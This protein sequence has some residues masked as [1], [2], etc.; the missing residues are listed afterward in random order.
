MEY[1]LEQMTKN[2]CIPVIDIFNFYVENSFAAFPENK[3]PYEFF[4]M[5]LE[6]TN[7]LPAVVAKTMGGE[8][9]GF[10]LLRPVNPIPTFSHACEIAYFIKPEYTGRGMGHTL[11]D[12]LVEKALE[13]DIETI[14]ACISSKNEGSIAFHRSHGFEECGRFRNICKKKGESFDVVWMQKML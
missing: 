8:I 4:D 10:G 13:S 6:K 14:L 9:M 11:L 3:V 7:G 2:D 12:H 1:T 5:F